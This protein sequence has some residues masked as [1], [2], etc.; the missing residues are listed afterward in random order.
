[1]KY[2]VELKYILY[3]Q[4]YLVFFFYSTPVLGVPGEKQNAVLLE[5]LHSAAH[6]RAGAGGWAGGVAGAGCWAGGER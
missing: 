2:L 3:I 5:S 1:M 4:F 6:C